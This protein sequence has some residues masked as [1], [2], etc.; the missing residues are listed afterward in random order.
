MKN[1]FLRL[2]LST[3][4]VF[5][6][7]CGAIIIIP[8]PAHAVT[9]YLAAKADGNLTDNT[10]WNL[11]DSAG[12]LDSEVASTSLIGTY[13]LSSSFAPGAITCDGIAVKVALRAAS[14]T[15]QTFTVSL[16]NSTDS[17]AVAGTEVAI[18][19]SDVPSCVSATTNEAGWVFFKW[20]SPVLLESL[21]NYKVQ[22]KTSA[23]SMIS[24]F[25][26]ATAGNWSRYLRTT[27]TQAPAAGDVMHIQREYTGSTTG[28]SWTVTMNQTATTDYG[29]GTDGV[30][31]T[32]PAM[33]I[34]NG[35]H[36][37]YGTS[38]ATNYYL[39]LSGSLIVYNGGYLDIGTTGTAIPRD[40]T[41]VL[42]FDPV[43]DAG[44]GL[45]VQSGA[46]FN[47]QGLSR[48][49]GK[50]IVK[51]LLNT[52]EDANQTTLG[53]N[54]DTGWLDNDV[55]GIASTSRTYSECETG[56]LNGNASSTE[57]TV[58]GFAGVGGGVA[59]AHSGTSP[60]QAEVILLTR[61]VKIRGATYDLVSYASF[62]GA[63]EVDIDWT[64]FSNFGHDLAL[65]RSIEITTTTGH[66]NIQYSSIY[67]TEQYGIAATGQFNENT[68]ISHNVMY[69]VSRLTPYTQGI[70]AVASTGTSITIDDNII[71]YIPFAGGTGISCADAGTVFTN[72]VVCGVN[73]GGMSFGESN[74]VVTNFSNNTAH[75]NASYGIILSQ[76]SYNSSFD[77][78]IVWRNAV[79]GLRADTN[80]RN[81]TIDNLIAF[82]NGTSNVEITA[83]SDITF[84]NPILNGDTSFAT[85][86]GFS[87]QPGA[88]AN[89]IYIIDGNFGTA[90]G[91][92]TTHTYDI[93]MS[94]MALVRM[95]LT[96]TY[97]NSNTECRNYST[98][99][100]NGSFIKSTNN[101]NAGNKDR[102]WKPN[103]YEENE[104]TI[105]KT[106]APS[107]EQN[108]ESSVNQLIGD[109]WYIP[110]DSGDSVT[111]TIYSRWDS[112]NTPGTNPQVT[113]EGCGIVADTKTNTAATTE[114]QQLT[115]TGTPSSKGFLTLT[116]KSIKSSSGTVVYWDDIT[117]TYAAGGSKS[118]GGLDYW[119]QA[120]PMYFGKVITSAN[121]L[122]ESWGT[123]IGL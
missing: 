16:Y 78:I 56:S 105:Y 64:E 26:D 111:V 79:R 44:M 82:G 86:S 19:V 120:L 76:S 103:G 118:L 42:E 67:N 123:I 8:T 45:T 51:T 96:N 113:L 70:Y 92:K 93:A 36:L 59:Y 23:N 41:A 55:I 116:P 62:K 37:T 60:T 38:A 52:D 33:T 12:Y 39:K 34:G 47:S 102:V 65:A 101:D 94:G 88:S 50:T 114:W 28:T 49:T 100:I 48:T 110:C 87:F 15:T 20:G 117:T 24:L 122:I 89:N 35:C 71:M 17:A 2:I 98:L 108:P 81:C 46:Y 30:F 1:N 69:N 43:A 27:Q 115:L 4:I 13:A 54:S 11:I 77:N 61:N 18:K 58:D 74:E 6:T 32:Y 53:V 95:F 10:T 25:R 85:L 75:S 121:N 97:L 73:G 22:A 68:V 31:T 14:P 7:I 109:P 9:S 21:H 40:S 107:L 104:I 57:L 5:G 72:N 112:A 90:S 106:D 3:F 29:V 80:L 83:V 84:N 91:I 63:S 119:Y 99:L 66:C